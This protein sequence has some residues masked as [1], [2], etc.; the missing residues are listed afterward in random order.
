MLFELYLFPLELQINQS[1]AVISLGA[2]E[3]MEMEIVLFGDRATALCRFLPRG[4]GV[5]SSRGCERESLGTFHSHLALC[6]R[7]RTESVGSNPGLYAFKP[8]K[9]GLLGRTFSTTLGV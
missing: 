9:P 8:V 1:P 5:P 7:R 4:P 2:D 6:C 3:H